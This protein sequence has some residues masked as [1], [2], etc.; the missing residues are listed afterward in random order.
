MYLVLSYSGLF[1]S[2]S[3]SMEKEAL[4]SDEADFVSAACDLEYMVQSLFLPHF[5]HLQIVHNNA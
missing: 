3:V 4:V 5:S 1:R 2:S